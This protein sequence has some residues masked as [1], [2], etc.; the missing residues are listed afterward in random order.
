MLVENNLMLGNSR[1][2][3][4]S[5]FGVKGGKEITFRNNTV[6]G[7]LPS[8]A[9]AMRL[10]TEGDNPPNED[11]HFYN[12]IWSDPA[13]TMGAENPSSSNDFSDT[14]P[15]ETRS[16]VLDTNLYWN[17]GQPV[18]R[19]G[20]EL[21]NYTDD[22]NALVAD[23]L[24]VAPSGIVLPRWDPA[25]GKFGD[26]STQS[27][28]PSR[29]WFHF[30]PYQVQPVGLLMLPIRIMLPTMT[31][32]ATRGPKALSRT[33]AHMKPKTRRQAT[34]SPSYFPYS[35]N[36]KDRS[37]LFPGRHHHK[38][39]LYNQFFVLIAPVDLHSHPLLFFQLFGHSGR[40]CDGI[41]MNTGLLN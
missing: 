32:S 29:N 41:P 1:N 38:G 9:F 2:V 17:G 22:A 3:M 28:R 35:S 33:W 40:S 27:A 30:M 7:D 23:P 11:I 16:F 15:G 13:G 19:D 4:R 26:G 31:S 20:G 21:I 39:P 24:L 18:P 6:N 37:A 14:P 36:R 5:P 8:K 10:N 12:N 34:C 25:F